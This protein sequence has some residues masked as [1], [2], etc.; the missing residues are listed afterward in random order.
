MTPPLQFPAGCG[1]LST[2]LHRLGAQQVLAYDTQDEEFTPTGL[3]RSELVLKL[4]PG[5]QSYDHFSAQQKRDTDALVLQLSG[6]IMANL[7]A[8]QSHPRE[9]FGRLTCSVLG[10]DKPRMVMGRLTAENILQMDL[11]QNPFFPSGPMDYSSMS[12]VDRANWHCIPL[13]CD[14]EKRN[15]ERTSE[16]GK[17][18][19]LQTLHL[20]VRPAHINNALGKIPLDT[21]V[22]AL[23]EFGRLPR[24]ARR[25]SQAEQAPGGLPFVA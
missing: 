2:L 6:R 5:P 18:P 12:S 3:R 8:G 4:S 1:S 21:L 19:V 25:F 24:F 13:L 14:Y 7:L 22:R 23:P 11:L 15:L 17:K 10:W 16:D 20:S 9:V